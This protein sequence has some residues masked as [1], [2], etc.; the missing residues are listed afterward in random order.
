MIKKLENHKSAQAHVV[1]VKDMR[2]LVSYTTEVLITDYT[3]NLMEVTGLYSNTTRRHISW[4]LMEY[5]PHID[6]YTIKR[7][8]EQN[9]KVNIITGEL[10]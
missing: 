10:V 3:T 8:Y 9:K 4:Y 2:Y 1:E 6:Y 5:F 7:A